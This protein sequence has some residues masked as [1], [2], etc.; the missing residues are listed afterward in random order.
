MKRTILSCLP[1]SGEVSVASA[2]DGG[3]VKIFTNFDYPSALL[4]LGSSPDKGSREEL[5]DNKN[6]P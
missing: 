5:R 6:E 2:T 3:V 4:A 1:L